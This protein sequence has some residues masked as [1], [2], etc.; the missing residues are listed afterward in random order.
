M[1]R[2]RRLQLIEALRGLAAADDALVLENARI[3]AAILD[4][5]GLDWADVIAQGGGQADLAD[6]FDH[7][8]F[9]LDGDDDAAEADGAP[10]EDSRL[11]ALLERLEAHAGISAE[12]RA[13]LA[14]FRRDLAEGSLDA[15]DRKYVVALAGRL[16]VKG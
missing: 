12:T 11:G 10:I 13:E 4:E 8:S 9:D 14:D 1:D 5:E 7:G 6:E 3:A 15:G 16:G 2:E